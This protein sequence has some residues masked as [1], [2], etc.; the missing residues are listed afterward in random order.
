MTKVVIHIHAIAHV[1]VEDRFPEARSKW[2]AAMLGCPP[3]PW[4]IVH[5]KKQAKHEESV[6]NSVQLR[7]E[8]R[9]LVQMCVACD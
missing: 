8:L 9:S 6:S 5:H 1:V 7:W 2:G 3:L 4:V